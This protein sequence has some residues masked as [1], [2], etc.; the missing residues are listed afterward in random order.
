MTTRAPTTVRSSPT[1][2][3]GNNVRRQC[4]ET[5]SQVVRGS[6]TVGGDFN[7]VRNTH[8]K[9]GGRPLRATRLKRFNDCIEACNLMDI[10]SSGNTFSWS[11]KQDNQIMGRLDRILANNDWLLLHPKATVIYHPQGLSD[12]SAM[13]LI[14]VPPFP[15]GPKPFKFFNA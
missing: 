4:K 13:H 7:E 12:H 5:I 14:L 6:W 1:Q 15:S 8:E 11:N 2:N 3:P 10:H 9:V